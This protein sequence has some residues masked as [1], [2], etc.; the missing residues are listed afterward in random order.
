VEARSKRIDT[1]KFGFAKI[2]K[3]GRAEEEKPRVFVFFHSSLLPVFVNMNRSIV[4][5]LRQSPPA[6]DAFT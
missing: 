2:T 4:K 3:M 1:A 5:L 6:F